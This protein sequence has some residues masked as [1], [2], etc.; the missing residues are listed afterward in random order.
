M[1]QPPLLA[2]AGVPSSLPRQAAPHCCCSPSVVTSV[3]AWMRAL[4]RHSPSSKDEC[5]LASS[6]A[7]FPKAMAAKTESLMAMMDPSLAI[8][9]TAKQ[10]IRDKLAIKYGNR[11]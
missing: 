3:R 6:A 4:L 9:E 10:E 8:L 1:A 11:A 2:A 7:P 5:A